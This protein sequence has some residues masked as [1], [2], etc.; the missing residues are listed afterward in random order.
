MTGRNLHG[1]DGFILEWVFLLSC[2]RGGAVR[3]GVLLVALFGALLGAGMWCA[4]ASA[5]PLGGFGGRG[6]FG[7][8]RDDENERRER[9]GRGD[10]DGFGGQRGGF[11]GGPGGSQGGPGGFRGGRG[12]FGGGPGGFDPSSFIDRLDRNNNGML[13]PDEMEGPANFMVQRLQREDPSIRTDRPIPLSKLKEGFERMRNNRGDPGGDNPDD[14][15]GDETLA[16]DVLVPGFGGVELPP[17]VPGFSAASELLAVRITDDDSREAEE[18]M[19]RYDRNRDGF[20]G[21]EELSRRWGAHAMD[22]DQNGDNKLSVNELAVR[23]A[24]RR[25]NEAEQATRR[26]NRNGRQPD[27]GENDAEEES[28]DR[29]GGRLS[30]RPQRDPVPEGLPGWFG[31]KDRNRDSQV[32]MSEFEQNWTEEKVQEFYSFDR[33]HDGTLTA[34]EVLRSVKEEGSSSRST[35]STAGPAGGPPSRVPSASASRTAPVTPVAPNDLDDK[36]VKYA[37]RIIS[38]SDTDR[39]G[40]LTVDEWKE[41]IMDV[42]PADADRDGRIT[43]PEYAGWL[44]AR[45]RK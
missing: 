39:N 18:N 30:Y 9:G 10:R 33:N 8:D 35:A 17:P 44:Q 2:F 19:R 32:T 38:R 14:D 11:G 31:D 21:S 37:E 29:F 6:G 15:E 26:D 20:I 5:Q 22:F 27:R 43:V 34:D 40:A 7:G 24:R 4:D 28:A 16:L 25:I 41:M 13:D 45:A 3:I 36:Y 23:A 1:A 42:S 12:G